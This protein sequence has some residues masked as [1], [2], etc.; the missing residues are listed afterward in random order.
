VTTVPTSRT[1]PLTAGASP[2]TAGSASAPALD[3]G[4]LP[5]HGESGRDESESRARRFADGLRALRVGGGR[6]ALGE[7]TLMIVGGVLAPLGMIVIL[8]GWFGAARTALLFEQVPYL[9]S[10]GLLGLGL[11]I[12]GSSMYFAH[13]I[14]ELVREHRSQSAALLAAIEGLRGDL[15]RAVSGGVVAPLNGTGIRSTAGTD[16]TW[17]ATPHGTLAHR[18]GCAVIVG[19]DDLRAVPG[20][21]VVARCRLC[22]PD[23]VAG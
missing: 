8:L 20:D 2:A 7:R 22:A 17:W 15:D 9:I 14:T 16:D 3:L 23:P 11:V 1:R 5:D 12:I 21:Q 4:A 10:G 19:K 18:S 6:L 13:W